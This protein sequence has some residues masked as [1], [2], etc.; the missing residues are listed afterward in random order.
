MTHKFIKTTFGDDY[1]GIKTVIDG[2]EVWATC[3][4]AVK[5]FAKM[6]FQEGDD[7]EFEFK[8]N[9][10]K[11]EISSNITKV[12]GNPKTETKKTS[13]SK[14][15]YSKYDKGQD[16]N[17]SIKRQAIAHAT[18][19]TMIGLQGHINPENVCKILREVYTTYQ[20]MVG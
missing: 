10:G 13:Y 11:Y 8:V 17:T 2:K 9:D 14:A 16:V 18:S 1:V 12:G 6:N 4:Q 7:V 20:E 15:T 3:S 19:R 5:E